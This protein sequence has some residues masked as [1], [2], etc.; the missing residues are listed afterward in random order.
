MLE[1]NKEEKHIL[2]ELKTTIRRKRKAIK[3]SRS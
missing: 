3:N 1:E 2:K